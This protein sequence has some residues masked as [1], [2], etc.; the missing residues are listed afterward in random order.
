MLEGNN[1]IT[2]DLKINY[3]VGGIFQDSKYDAGPYCCR[4]S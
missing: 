4:W 1:V 2:D 3:R